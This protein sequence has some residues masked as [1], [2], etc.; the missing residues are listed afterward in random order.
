LKLHHYRQKPD[1]QIQTGLQK[2]ENK[3]IE[4]Y[5]DKKKIITQHLTV[6]FVPLKFVSLAFYDFVAAD[7]NHLLPNLVNRHKLFL[8]SFVLLGIVP[9]N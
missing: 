8:V 5:F 1:S 3:T 2:A 9:D 7:V 6:E 4:N